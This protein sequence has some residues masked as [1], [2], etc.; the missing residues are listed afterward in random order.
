MRHHLA[1]LRQTVLLIFTL[2]IAPTVLALEI[3]GGAEGTATDLSGS[4]STEPS[5]FSGSCDNNSTGYKV[6]A[7][8]QLIPLTAL[9]VGYI[10]FGKAQASGMLAGTAVSR[11]MSG[12]ATYLA[13]VLRGTSSTG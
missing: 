7:G 10:D 9:E 4:C 3:Y 12:N 6:F 13:F 11:E 8:F 2:C 1:T 5:G